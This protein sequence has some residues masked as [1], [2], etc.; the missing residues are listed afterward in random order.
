[1]ASFYDEMAN[2]ALDLISEFGQN[3]T[4]QDETPG[5]YDPVT[6]T[7]TLGTLVEQIGRCVLQE[8]TGQDYASNT[9]IQQG[10]K[11]IKIAAKGLTAPQ[12]TTKLITGGATWVIVNIKSSNPAGTPLVYEVHGR[13]A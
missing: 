3:V 7:Q 9:L 5:S 8:F 1:M 12:M 4:L 13:R 10:D 6:G 11:K 2:M